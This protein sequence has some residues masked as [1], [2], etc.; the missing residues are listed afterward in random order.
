MDGVF[1]VF[2]PSAQ[3][4]RL[5][6]EEQALFDERQEARR[7]RDFARADA[8]R[9]ALEALGVRRRGHAQGPALA[10]EAIALWRATAARPG[11][12]GEDLACAYLR[13][14]GAADRWSGTSAAARGEID[15]IARDGSTR[16]LRR[17]QGADRRRLTAPPSRP[18][19]PLKRS[20]VVRAARL[21]AAQHAPP[22]RRCASTSSRSTGGPRARRSGT[23]P[24]PSTPRATELDPSRL[25]RKGEKTPGTPVWGLWDSL[26]LAILGLARAAREVWSGK[27]DSNPRLRPW[28]GR[29]LPLS[30]SR[31]QPSEDKRA[32]AS[33]VKRRAGLLQRY[34]PLIS[35]SV[36]GVSYSPAAGRRSQVARRRS[37]KPLFGGSTPAAA[38]KPSSALADP[39]STRTDRTDCLHQRTPGRRR[40]TT[41]ASENGRLPGIGAWHPSCLG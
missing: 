41:K 37:A 26:W 8:A 1:G 3:E 19:R 25:D 38:S 11:Q 29:T 6:A 36:R 39:G 33:F 17:G 21:Y 24:V 23:R 22:S 12:A 10:A 34:A 40:P 27:R 5:S 15:I 14:E 2:L 4:D 30:Y 35:I 18:S 9:A 32:A 13:A 20:R 28:Q 7:K 16:G 31:P